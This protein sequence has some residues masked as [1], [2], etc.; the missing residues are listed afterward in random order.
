MTRALFARDTRT[1]RTP[2]LGASRAR[3]LPVLMRDI[4]RDIMR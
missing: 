2:A 4:M 1:R 3:S